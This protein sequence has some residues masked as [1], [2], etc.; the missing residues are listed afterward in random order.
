MFGEVKTVK[1]WIRRYVLAWLKDLKEFDVKSSICIWHSLIPVKTLLFRF[2]L[3]LRQWT[4]PVKIQL[5]LPVS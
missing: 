2:L 3:G 1:V 4:E 5:F